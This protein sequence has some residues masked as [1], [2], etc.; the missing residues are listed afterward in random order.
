MPRY[1]D[2]DLQG[3]DFSK[4]QFETITSINRAEALS[5]IEEIK[6]FFDKFGEKLPPELE[7]QRQ[8]FGKRAEKAP[9]VWRVVDAA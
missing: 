3:L 6:G 7:K 8:E 1:E 5:E 4:A 2:L 9:E